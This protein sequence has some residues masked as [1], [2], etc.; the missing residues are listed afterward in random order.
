MWE[1]CTPSQ[2]EWLTCKERFLLCFLFLRKHLD[3]QHSLVLCGLRGFLLCLC[4]YFRHER[5]M[6]SFSSPVS[7]KGL[8]LSSVLGGR[9]C[10]F[11]LF[12]NLNL[13]WDRVGENQKKNAD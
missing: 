13:K 2:A 11:F 7:L 5:T 1:I 10:N 12:S 8:L 4:S 9:G 3:L 6:L